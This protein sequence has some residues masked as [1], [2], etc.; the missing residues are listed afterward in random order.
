MSLYLNRFYDKRAKSKERIQNEPKII[1][2]KTKWAIIYYYVTYF[3][4]YPKCNI[5]FYYVPKSS[6]RLVLN[7]IIIQI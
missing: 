3:N 4:Y 2:V 5:M 7:Y 1:L 6:K